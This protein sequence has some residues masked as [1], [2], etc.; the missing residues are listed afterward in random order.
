MS[1]TRSINDVADEILKLQ[2]SRKKL[3]DKADV[4]KKQEDEL[5]LEIQKLAT[6]AKLTFGGNKKSAWS[7]SPLIVPQC[8][9][10]DAF[11]DYIHKK[12]YFHLLERRPTVK[13]CQ[14]LWGLGERIPGIDKFTKVRVNV[15][16]V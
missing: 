7:I 5:K 14:E 16:E 9:D 4:I 13:A 15:K 8:S 11:Y 6:E 10:W 12:K 2:V 3:E 1:G